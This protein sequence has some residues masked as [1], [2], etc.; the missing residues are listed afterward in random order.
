MDVCLVCFVLLLVEASATGRSL[1]QRSP[2]DC[3]CVIVCDLEQWYSAW[4]YVK[5]KIYIYKTC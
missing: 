2:T 5:L 3:E 4:G 1:V